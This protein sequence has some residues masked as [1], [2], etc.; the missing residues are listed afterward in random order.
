[1][2]DR[3]VVVHQSIYNGLLT[4]AVSIGTNNIAQIIE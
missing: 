2:D 1:M 3:H 4:M